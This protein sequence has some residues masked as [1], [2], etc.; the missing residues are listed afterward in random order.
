M[1]FAGKG[2]RWFLCLRHDAWRTDELQ[3]G[4]ITLIR[5]GS[6]ITFFSSSSGERTE[7]RDLALSHST[8]NLGRPSVNGTLTPSFSRY[9]ITGMQHL[10]ASRSAM[11][12]EFFRSL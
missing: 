9:L 1:V 7:A 12:S 5:E 2:F 10:C 8:T 11:L 3:K 4:S 6:K